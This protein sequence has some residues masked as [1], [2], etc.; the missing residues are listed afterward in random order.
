MQFETK[1][2]TIALLA[3][4]PIAVYIIPTLFLALGEFLV[5]LLTKN[6][7][8]LMHEF[9]KAEIGGYENMLYFIASVIVF[10]IILLIVFIFSV[11]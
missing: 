2:I 5:R 6:S 11:I 1:F 8:K 10:Y 4:L 9:Y 3:L 7:P